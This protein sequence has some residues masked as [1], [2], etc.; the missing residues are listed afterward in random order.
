MG[1]HREALGYLDHH[2]YLDKYHYDF[3]DIYGNLSGEVFQSHPVIKDKY[4]A[5]D[6]I[7]EYIAGRDYTSMDEV[8]RYCRKHFL[9]DCL[10]SRW[11]QVNTLV[12]EHNMIE[13]N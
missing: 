2:K 13:K 9:L 8:Y 1:F 5:F 7:V 10:F 12:I 4:L 3:K 6:N 11:S